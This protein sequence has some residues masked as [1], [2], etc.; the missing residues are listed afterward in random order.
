MTTIE[1]VTVKK[2]NLSF[3]DFI[4]FE[5]NDQLD[6]ND[7]SV[8]D[9]CIHCGEKGHGKVNCLDKKTVESLKSNWGSI[10][11]LGYEDARKNAFMCIEYET[12]EHYVPS[13]DMFILQVDTV[14]T[15]EKKCGRD[16]IP[17]LDLEERESEDSGT[18]VITDTEIVSSS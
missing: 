13:G 15:D 7:D 11:G 8:I 1:G 16:T 12:V 3:V 10:H 6:A 17:K 5:K 4:F 9:Y 18:V 14:N 2:G